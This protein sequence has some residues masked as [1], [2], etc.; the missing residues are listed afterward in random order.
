M[1]N[2]AIIRQACCNHWDC[3]ACGTVRAS[4]EYRRIVAGAE[5]LATEHTLYFWTI[6]C[7]GREISLDEAEENYYAWT[8]RFLTNARA[9]ANRAGQFWVYVQITERQKKTRLHPHSH[10][11]TSF[12]PRD[13]VAT[14]DPNE[15]RAY[16]SLWFTRAN[17]SSG[18]GSQHRI[19]EVE[20]AAAT[21]RYVAKYM[22]K[23]TMMEKWPAKWKRVR[24]S[25]NWPKLPQYTPDF[26]AVLNTPED[27]HKVAR[28]PATFVCSDIRDYEVARHRI[29]NIAL[30]VGDVLF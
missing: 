26:S 29:A 27:W 15:R 13:A 16:V 9:K 24:Y 21:A 10:I 22:F 18:L 7:R 4:Q 8:N 28:N 14:T 5:S 17:Q 12:L 25:R 30:R 2:Q 3:P 11:I 19:T 23:D 20:S 6:T 1:E